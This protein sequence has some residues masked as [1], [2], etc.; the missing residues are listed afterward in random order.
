[1]EFDR[2]KHIAVDLETTGDEDEFGLQPWRVAQGRATIRAMSTAWWDENGRPQVKGVLDPTRE[3]IREL[4]QFASQTNKMLVGWNTPFDAS[5]MLAYGLEQEVMACRWLDAQLLWKHAEREPEYDV[6]GQKRKGWALEDAVREYMPRHVGFKQITNFHTTDPEELQ[7]LLHRNKM[8]ALCT[9]KLAE[10]F[11]NMLV[12]TQQRC[13]TIE[14]A[15]ISPIAGANLRGLDTNVAQCAYLDQKLGVV[16]H[17]RLLELANHGATPEILASPQQLAGLLYDK[18]GLPVAAS[19]ARTRSHCMNWHHQTSGRSWSRTT[20]RRTT[21]ARSSLPT[22]LRLRSITVMAIP[23][24]PSGCTA[25]TQ[26]VWCTHPHRV[27]VSR[28]SRPASPS[29]R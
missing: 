18:W 27:V 22:S 7:R 4:L 20:E 9:L 5:W 11:W 25:P 2:S 21:T 13:A 6:K 24:R 23:T 10:I 28:K 14:A 16:A 1:M 15:A 26:D 29:H 12:P 8:D 3:Q 19:A 17:E